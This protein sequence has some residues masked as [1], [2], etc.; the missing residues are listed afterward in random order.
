MNSNSKL[1]YSILGCLI[2]A[3]LKNPLLESASFGIFENGRGIT[4][5]MIY[6]VYSFLI[7][8]LSFTGFILLIVF[9]IKLIINNI[10]KEK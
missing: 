6:Q 3:L 1:L 9:S 5:A 8:L 7:N 2:L 10:K 4:L